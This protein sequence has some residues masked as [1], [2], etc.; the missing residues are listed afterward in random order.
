MSLLKLANGS[1]IEVAE[2]AYRVIPVEELQ[3]IAA[4]RAESLAEVQVLLPET[5]APAAPVETEVPAEQPA[6]AP[7]EPAQAE[8]PAEAPAA[9]QPADEA[10]A[11]PAEPMNEPTTSV[12]L[13]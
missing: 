4:D 2:D 3:Q 7:A 5:E 11:A 6:E 9:E 10:V 1:V 13:N 8:A 12:V